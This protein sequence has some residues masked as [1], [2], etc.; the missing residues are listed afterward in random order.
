MHVIQSGIKFFNT[1]KKF[2]DMT[3]FENGI[4]Y[5]FMREFYMNSFIVYI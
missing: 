3:N 5:D 1:V 2:S 4:Y